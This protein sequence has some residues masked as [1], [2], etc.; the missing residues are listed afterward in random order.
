M[1]IQSY[2]DGLI[3][4]S[5]LFASSKIRVSQIVIIVLMN[6]KIYD[7]IMA[8]VQTEREKYCVA[9]SVDLNK[10]SNLITK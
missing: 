10:I 4:M 7:Y 1:N 6:I 3:M 9:R 5:L 8:Y 2:P